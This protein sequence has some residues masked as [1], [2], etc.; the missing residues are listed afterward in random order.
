MLTSFQRHSPYDI[1]RICKFSQEFF[2]LLYTVYRVFILE[3]L[4]S[5]A[6]MYKGIS[7]RRLNIMIPLVSSYWTD[8]NSAFSEKSMLVIKKLASNMHIL[9]YL[10]RKREFKIKRWAVN[11]GLSVHILTWEIGELEGL[12]KGPEVFLS[13]QDGDGYDS[14]D[15]LDDV[16][17]QLGGL[18]SSWNPGQCIQSSFQ[19][20]L[21]E[22]IDG[23]HRFISLASEK[24]Y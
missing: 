24:I 18:S 12:G 2:L 9:L 17:F 10:K 23:S 5:L 6:I 15:S 1:H 16:I 3:E 19:N 21:C 20:D 13:S 22:S 7:E 11:I 4:S 14:S 8:C